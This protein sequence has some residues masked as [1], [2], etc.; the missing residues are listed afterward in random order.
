MIKLAKEVE[1]A[2]KNKRGIEWKEGYNTLTQELVK[3]MLD[4][5]ETPQG[6]HTELI[7]PKLYKKVILVSGGMDST[8]MWWLNGQE[9]DKIAL[10]ANLG[11]SYNKKEFAAI[12]RACMKPLEVINYPL[13]FDDNWKHIIPTRNF[14]LL[15]LAEQLVA[16]EGEIWIGAVQGETET[17]KG[18]KSDLFFR[19]VEEYIWR[20]KNKK[21]FIKDLK[22]HTKNDWLRIYLNATNDKSILDTVTC[23][24]GGVISCGKCQG[25]VRKAIAMKYCGLDTT[26]YFKI[27]PFIGGKKYVDKYK[28]KMQEA[29]DKKDFTHYSE[30]RAKQD[31]TVINNYDKENV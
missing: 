3:V 18:D 20:T 13:K 19:L 12:Q 28:I 29:L 6:L 1:Q 21:V 25:C 16:H 9:Q 22:E 8:I 4:F 23:F 30:D 5:P 27:D 2:I 11:Q 14:V 7:L 15:A 17:T 31:L 24:D 26:E 10:Y